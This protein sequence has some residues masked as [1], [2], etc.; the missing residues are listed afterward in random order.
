MNGWYI[1]GIA[2][3]IMVVAL[4]GV[5]LAKYGGKGR[6][7]TGGYDER[8]IAAQGKAHKRAY[9]TLGVLSMA[10]GLADLLIE[11]PWCSAIAGL[12]ICV[13]A[14]IG[15]WATVCIMND[16]YFRT[17]DST[18]YYM[19][20]FGLMGLFNVA[21]GAMRIADGSILENGELGL[22]SMNLTV[23]LLSLWLMAVIIVKLRRDR[24]DPESAEEV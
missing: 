9:I 5:L 22:Y 3:G 6:F 20:L 4:A 7:S 2:A 8:Q 18:K 14:S 21:I 1:A 11:R 23:G 19:R 15:V 13:C 17:G 24:R 16:A 12:F 10:Y